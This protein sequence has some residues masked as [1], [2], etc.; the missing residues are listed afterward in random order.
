MSTLTV[1]TRPAR[2]DDAV[3]LDGFVDGCVP[4][5]PPTPRL[6]P[7][8]R[9]FSSIFPF[10]PALTLVTPF[11]TYRS[12]Q[13]KLYGRFNLG[14]LIENATATV[15]AIDP[16]HDDAVVGFL[17]ITRDIPLPFG[18]PKDRGLERMQWAKG[19]ASAVGFPS[20][21]AAWVAG[22]GVKGGYEKVAVA[23]MLKTAFQLLPHLDGVL[24][25]A[26]PE[27]EREPV[28]TSF[29]KMARTMK[30]ALY[31]AS[32]ESVLPRLRV[33]R[34]RVDDHD[35]LL[36][37]VMSAAGDEYAAGGPLS[38]LPDGGAST[39]D[40]GGL[41]DEYALATLISRALDDPERKCVL[42]AE[43]EEGKTGK[44]SFVGVV[45]VNAVDAEEAASL[46]G[47]YDLAAYDNLMPPAE[48]DGAAVEADKEPVAIRVTMLCVDRAYES[49]SADFLQHAFDAFP[50]KDFCVV[51]LPPQAPELPL[52][53]LAM[54]RVAPMDPEAD[55]A[56][57]ACHRAGQLRGFTV[58]LA[59][60][61]DYEEV[62]DLLEGMADQ[63]ELCTAFADA[64][65]ASNTSQ[66][67]VVAICEDQ[68]VG[69]ATVTLGT[70]I[71]SLAQCFDLNEV[72]DVGAHGQS[73][74]VE[75]EDCVMNP[76]FAHKRRF[77]MCEAMRLSRATCV[78]YQL[79]PG[80]EEPPPP[81]V[82]SL[83]FRLVAGRR[84]HTGFD[85]HFAL[86]AFTN[87]ISNS[88]R[89]A[90][91]SRIVVVGSNE[92][93][94]AV[95]D[96]LLTNNRCAFNN[97]TLVTNGGLAVGGVASRYNR[98][99]IAKLALEN[100][101]GNTST[102]GA[103]VALVDA[104]V[105]GLDREGRCVYLDDDSMLM[106][107]M[108][109]LVPGRGDQTRHRLGLTL[110][111][112]TP[113]ER[114]VDL[115]ANLTK[116]DAERLKAV[117][118][119]GDTM[120]A[121]GAVRRLLTAGVPAAALRVVSPTEEGTIFS[122]AEVAASKL[123]VTESHTV[124]GQPAPERGLALT[125]ATAVPGGGVHAVFS[126]VETGET[127]DMDADVLVVCD[128]GDCDPP[129][130]KCLNDAEI[131]Y[132]G[133]VVIDAAFR[134]NDPDVYATG[135]IAKFS[136]RYA[137]EGG[138]LQ[139]L[140]RH[141]PKESGF[142]LADSLIDR[143]RGL[144]ARGTPPAFNAPK[145]ESVILPGKCQFLFVAKPARFERPSWDAP[146]GGRAVET[147]SDERGYARIDVDANG[148]VSAF[149]YC[150]DAKVDAQRMGCIV[151]L[152]VAYLGEE[153][154]SAACL[155]THL[156]R[157]EFAAVFHDGFAQQ[158]RSAMTLL[159]APKDALAESFLGAQN[160]AAIVQEV[161]I[162]FVRRHASD[163]PQLAIPSMA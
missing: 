89:A 152:P 13:G 141:D 157:D 133:H 144:P 3:Q 66:T 37:L 23:P 75:L 120:E 54:R 62:W 25:A 56:L 88:P 32:R 142:L 95:L 87:R 90:I 123:R 36:P 159:S 125:G 68:V 59:K 92:A 80:E 15:V 131:V 155:L 158:H 60:D 73:A 83:D 63:E 108:L 85:A 49:Q 118:V 150:G 33:R 140:D 78:L 134:T 105:V 147:R 111:D 113:V 146:A 19:E 82:V 139:P 117:I 57:H 4:D 30:F 101:G 8:S 29:V 50:S 93:A 45:A 115:M 98:A 124:A 100:G 86:Y 12:H 69:Y 43:A 2:P 14:Q 96:R 154:S 97:V 128:R 74:F 116:E 114:V 38:R 46:A 112:E 16:Q 138:R 110:E 53:T 47:K 143:V 77:V 71:S 39:S 61:D 20:D 6:G 55:D 67:A 103:G 79:A 18:V 44:M 148:I 70:E 149:Y 122:V 24:I 7:P 137:S 65:A 161:I 135:D 11:P 84:S 5:P 31:A 64:A 106:Y 51:T 40:T 130:F 58:R 109:V 104:A 132:D 42:V 26:P 99:S 91:N 160:D 34:A 145:C 121:M 41:G 107:E 126:R 129:L 76:I 9:D 27:V 102:G 151:G 22:C 136:R 1:V 28:G 10:S 119:Y 127:V 94:L 72:V 163:L 52:A 156:D 21:V 162:D 153:L 35:D 17:A 48:D 81:D